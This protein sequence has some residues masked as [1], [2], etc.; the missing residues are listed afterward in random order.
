MR[1]SPLVLNFIIGGVL[2]AAAGQTADSRVMAPG[3]PI[4]DSLT[5]V[6]QSQTYALTL[7]AGR[8]V[9]IAVRQTQRQPVMTVVDPGG[10]TVVN[11][12]WG[13]GS[14]IAEVSGRY[15]LRLRASAV[16][17]TPGRYEIVVEPPRTPSAAETARAAGDK[18]FAEGAQVVA[19]LVTTGGPSSGAASSGA[20][21][22]SAKSAVPRFEAALASYREAGYQRGELAAL[23][24]IGRHGQL[25]PQAARAQLNAA[26]TLA[27][28]LGDRAR[29]AEALQLLGITYSRR[30]ERAT[31]LDHQRRALAIFEAL[32]D[33]SGASSAL[34][35]MALACHDLGQYQQALDY[36]ARALALAER[37]DDRGQIGRIYNNRGQTLITL[38]KLPEALE[39][40]RRALPL[41]PLS[42]SAVLELMVHH[43]TGVAYK[44]MGEYGKAR[45]AL[46]LAL[47]GYRRLGD[48]FREAQTLNTIGNVLRSEGDE[49]KAIEF[50]TEALQMARRLDQRVLEGQALNNMGAAY[51]QLGDYRRALEHHQQSRTL[52]HTIGDRSGEASALNR[53][54]VAS[55]KLGDI[56]GARGALRESLRLR[57]QLSET[58]AEAETLLNLAMVERDSGDAAAARATV[59]AALTIT[60]SLRARISD[61]AL[62]ASYIARVQE[63]YATYVDVLMALHAQSPSAGHDGAALEAADRSRARVLLESLG[64]ARADIREGI[65]PAL[66]TRERDVQQQVDHASE[67]L[68]EALA[69]SAGEAAVTTARTALG[70]IQDEYQQVQSRIRMS[71]PRYAALTQ[72]EPLRLATLQREI[73]DE[74]TIL[75]E[76][77]LGEQRSWLWAVTP[78]EVVSVGLP[79]RHEVEAAARA[80]YTDLIARQPQGRESSAAYA[81]RVAAADRRVRDGAAAIS[82][83][84]FG[85][86][87]ERLQGE[88]RGKRLAIVASGALDYLPFAAL[89]MPTA[90]GEPKTSGDDGGLPAALPVS[91]ASG[92]PKT[93]DAPPT[94]LIAQHEIVEAPS[95]SVLATLRREAA[96]RQPARRAVAVLADPVFDP[97]DPRIAAARPP[98]PAAKPAPPRAASTTRAGLARLPFSRAEADAI[99]SLARP[100]NTLRATD[101]RA[102]RTAVLGDALADYRIVHFATHG[103]IDSERPELSG[104]VLS[105]V[106]DRGAPQDG[107]VRLHDIFNMR[108]NADLVV[109]SACRT[110]VGKEIRGEGLIGLTR[111]FM[112]AGAPRVVASL[113]QISDLPTAELMKRFYRGMLQERLRPAAALRAAQRQMA[114]DPRWSA[115]YF[116]AGFVLQGDWQ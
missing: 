3:V 57:R 68:S 7:E 5:A 69:Q 93:S 86:I 31:A 81:A 82:Q 16:G 59:E 29:E 10:R 41:V 40:F 9:A 6:G 39:Q 80:W 28:T 89:P 37:V 104:L 12:T 64:E 98:K 1:A 74:D 73:L 23:L 47:A 50:Y 18:A 45:D 95:A 4:A 90:G 14:L 48:A 63:T 65:D 22:A 91:I 8:F 53:A 112:Y 67:R 61:P 110:A 21:P 76:L 100:E 2:T 30:T 62:R 15:L 66:L 83:M 32:D 87:A 19:Q 85:G 105:L 25:P 60:E 114:S 72:P 77:S 109:L 52:R 78:R 35:G 55:Y 11:S 42:G 51:A 34:N 44:E 106:T 79:S 108:L 97:Q 33:L 49:R 70:A 75:L 26:L 17:T 99:V 115:P 102:T 96:G 94:P 113:W 38:G 36:Y 101:F 103:L 88:W 92:D 54:G 58:S 46:A 24:M 107:M 20:A 71:S 43:N 116:W 27:G 111:G 56:D 13:E 84:L